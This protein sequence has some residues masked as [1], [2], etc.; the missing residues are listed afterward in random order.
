MRAS[1]AAAAVILAI[2][3]CGSSSAASPTSSTAPVA[4]TPASPTSSTATTATTPASPTSSTATVAA[5]PGAAAC[6]PSSER[7]LLSNRQARVYASTGFVYGCATG[8][9]RTYRLG[10]LTDCMRSAR[11]API[12]LAG[13]IVAYGLQR[14]GVDT[15]SSQVLVQRLSDGRQLRTL[16]T[17]TGPAAPESYVQ[18]ASL[19]VRADGAVAWIGI[20]HSIVRRTQDIEVHR[21]DRRGE[22]ELDSGPA[23]V[24]GSLR[25]MGSTLTWRHGAAT[26]TANLL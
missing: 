12:R 19:V 6:G 11:A 16:S 2:A 22:T 7:T 14:C 4:T 10:S 13:R 5:T 20:A 9:G 24:P 3:A 18:V 15:G 23:V 17:T 21:A 1:P 26:R 25:L 8:A